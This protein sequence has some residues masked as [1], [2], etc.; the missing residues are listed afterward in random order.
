MQANLLA[1]V[2]KGKPIQVGGVGT[3]DARVERSSMV[4]RRGMY[5]GRRAPSTRRGRHKLCQQQR[6]AR[7]AAAWLG[8]PGS[9]PTPWS[10]T[11]YARA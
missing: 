7:A 6:R 3:A 9:V 10:A 4:P 11:P 1:L 2:I 8:K 5:W